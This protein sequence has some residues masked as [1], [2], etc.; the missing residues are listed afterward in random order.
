MYKKLYLHLYKYIDVSK[1][2]F[3]SADFREFTSIVLIVP[4]NFPSSIEHA[5]RS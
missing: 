3:P 4:R 2:E 1:V 5:Y